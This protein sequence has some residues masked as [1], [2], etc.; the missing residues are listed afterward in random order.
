M[1]GNKTPG[2][3]E[4]N[5][6]W[7]ISWPVRFVW[8]EVWIKQMDVSLCVISE[9]VV[10]FKETQS[11]WIPLGKSLQFV[12]GLCWLRLANAAVWG[13][14]K[15]TI[16]RQQVC[17]V[18]SLGEEGCWN[19]ETET[20]ITCFVLKQLLTRK[21]LDTFYVLSFSHLCFTWHVTC[22]FLKKKKKDHPIHIQSVSTVF[23]FR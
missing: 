3:Q 16:D 17:P 9:I 10:H 11:A 18:T 4:E 22:G 8:F 15:I 20:N 1:Q 23:W 6:R 21:A 13:N 19:L 2:W 12:G 14:R 7:K 5:S